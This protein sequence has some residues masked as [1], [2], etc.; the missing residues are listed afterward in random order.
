MRQHIAEMVGGPGTLR[1]FLQPAMAIA[2]GILHG[3]R[4][5]RMGRP[6]YLVGLIGAQGG[7]LHLLGEALREILVPLAVALIGA[8][9]FQYIIRSHIYPLYALLYAL[10]FVAVPYLA[11]RGLANRAAR[12][13]T[14]SRRTS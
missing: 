1:F 2:L 11:T 8:F 4:D 6:P 14:T 13:R 12:R 9:T 5:R 3:V 7:R 10:F